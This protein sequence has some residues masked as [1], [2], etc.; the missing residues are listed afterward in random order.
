[1]GIVILGCITIHFSG[2]WEGFKIGLSKII[3]KDIVSGNG[4]TPDGYSSKIAIPG[5]IQFVSD[6]SKSVG[7][8]WT[9]M[10]CMT[11][12][13]ALMGIQASP[14]FSMWSFSNMTSKAFRWQQVVASSLIIGLIL[15]TFTI[16]QG[17]G[18]HI[19][20]KW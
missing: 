7:G 17:L 20:E 18:G 14:A 8:P 10:M 1:M 9:G 19:L 5:S 11:Y 15:F 3:S 2:G 13:F 4:L 12:M 16:F 6:G